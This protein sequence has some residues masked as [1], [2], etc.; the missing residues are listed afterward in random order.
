MLVV[1]LVLKKAIIRTAEAL[2]VQ[3]LWLIDP[4]SAAAAAAVSLSQ[5]FTF[6]AA[7][8]THAHANTYARIY[9]VNIFQS[10]VCAASFSGT[11]SW[12]LPFFPET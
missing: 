4:P 10:G 9:S 11:R 1:P 8:I 5:S 7:H 2:G 3:H 12:H 6:S